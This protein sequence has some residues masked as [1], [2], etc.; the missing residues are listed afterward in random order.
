YMAAR[1]TCSTV[2]ESLRPKLLS[3]MPERTSLLT[4][5]TKSGFLSNFLGAVHNGTAS[6]FVPEPESNG[7]E[8]NPLMIE[9]RMFISYFTFIWD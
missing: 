4:N 7:M 9:Y 2:G 1:N 6:F 5:F 8:V 3:L